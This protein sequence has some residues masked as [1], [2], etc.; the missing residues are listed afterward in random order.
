VSKDKSNTVEQRSAPRG[1][2]L[3]GR[4]NRNRGLE[5]LIKEAVEPGPDA[6]ITVQFLI[7]SPGNGDHHKSASEVIH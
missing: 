1:S 4:E 2:I 5:I 7:L 6:D 3:I